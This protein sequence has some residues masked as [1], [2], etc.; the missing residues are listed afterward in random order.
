[1]QENFL[2]PKTRGRLTLIK[3]KYR[4]IPVEK[5]EQHTYGRTQTHPTETLAL[6]PAE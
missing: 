3:E 6:A 1:M 5:R 4:W 2:H